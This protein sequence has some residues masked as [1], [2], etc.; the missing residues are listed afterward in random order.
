MSQR[1]AR[2]S[3]T[4]LPTARL[5]AHFTVRLVPQ[6][7]RVAPITDCPLPMSSRLARMSKTS[8]PISR[9]VALLTRVSITHIAK[10]CP[11]VVAHCLQGVGADPDVVGVVSGAMASG[12]PWSVMW[13]KAKSASNA[14]RPSSFAACWAAVRAARHNVTM[15]PSMRSISS[16]DFGRHWRWSNPPIGRQVNRVV[17][18]GLHLGQRWAKNWFG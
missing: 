1:L 11:H 10:S 13:L 16:A 15:I 8:L 3:K 2:L 9:Y 14:G 17:R 4:S 18:R 7:R 12:P 5:V 6:A